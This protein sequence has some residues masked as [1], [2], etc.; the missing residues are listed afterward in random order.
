MDT[1]DSAPNEAKQETEI[2][3]IE[4]PRPPQKLLA[5][6]F[7]EKVLGAP[8]YVVSIADSF[9]L[10][11]SAP[12]IERSSIFFPFLLNL[13]IPFFSIFFHTLEHIKQ[14][15]IKGRSNG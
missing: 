8:K 10:F 13:S 11:F 9:L 4:I 5:M 1:T 12:L 6:E 15:I 3:T 7:Y 2:N 14:K